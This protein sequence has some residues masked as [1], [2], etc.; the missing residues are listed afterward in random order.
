MWD[1]NQS[2][3]VRIYRTF[4][5]NAAEEESEKLWRKFHSTSS[6]AV[7]LAV[8][9]RGFFLSKGGE[10][11]APWM[12]EHARNA[13]EALVELGDTEKLEEFERRGWLD[14]E[15]TE[16]LLHLAI[17]QRRSGMTVWLLRLKEQKYG[18]P[19]RDFQLW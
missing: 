18:F 13:A 1:D 11:Y 7:R 17:G 19:D 15:L 8:A 16:R 6:E 3:A 4:E 9:L 2:D 10:E 14:A 5:V 12:E